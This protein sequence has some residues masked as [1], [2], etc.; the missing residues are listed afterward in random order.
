[1]HLATCSPVGE[2]RSLKAVKSIYIHPT[3][4]NEI[5]FISKS[6]VTVVECTFTKS[7]FLFFKH[8]IG[9][10]LFLMIWSSTFFQH[11]FSEKN[12]LKMTSIKITA[13]F[14]IL[15]VKFLREKLEL[16]P[17]LGTI[18]FSTTIYQRVMDASVK[19]THL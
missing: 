2:S 8:Y 1:M 18:T 9:K 16:P 17:P 10:L 7:F 11:I 12:I 3:F 5:L 14:D 15:R 13:P 6:E 19:I 4:W